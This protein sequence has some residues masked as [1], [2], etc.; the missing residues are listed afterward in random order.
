MMIHK[1]VVPVLVSPALLKVMV[2]GTDVLTKHPLFFR[3]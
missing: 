2:D 3:R 1:V